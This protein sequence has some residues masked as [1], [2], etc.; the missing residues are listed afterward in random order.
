MLNWNRGRNE[1]EHG[2]GWLMMED[3]TMIEMGS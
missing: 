2:G 3:G 1:E